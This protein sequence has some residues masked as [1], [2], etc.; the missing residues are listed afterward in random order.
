MG[1]GKYLSWENFLGS[2]LVTGQ[3]RVHRISVSPLIELFW[4]GERKSVGI[5]LQADGVN[6]VPDAANRLASVT[7]KLI[8]QYGIP[9]LEIRTTS[10]LVNRE[11][12]LFA[13]AVADRIL[14]T[15]QSASEAVS[16]ELACFGALF[17]QKRILSVERQI[18][19]LGELIV[20]ERIIAA[21]GADAIEAWIGPQGEPH[22]FRIAANEFEIKTSSGTRRIH[23]IN[24]LAQLIASPG[25]GLFLMSILVGPGGKG[26]GFSLASKVIAIRR[27]LAASLNRQT[28][29]QAALEALG[30]SPLDHAHYE[31][32][33]SLRRP[34]A[35]VPIDARFPSIT[36]SSLLALLGKEANRVDRLVYDV[37]IEGLESGEG[38]DLF[39]SVFPYKVVA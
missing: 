2:V 26:A 16:Y 38:T 29:F 23:T 6:I 24:N 14:E 37:N 10:A 13:N 33:F 31:R 15:G 35:I 11:F 1:S 9:V 30:Y 32:P 17:E 36:S 12:Y 28:Q 25:S 4:D 3:Q 34:L 22:D 19:L 39:Q 8:E 27:S 18:G 7:W 5:W 21:E 20:L